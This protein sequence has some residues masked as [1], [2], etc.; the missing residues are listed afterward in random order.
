MIEKLTKIKDSIG[1]QIEYI[2]FIPS[3]G[4]FENKILSAM[5]VHRAELVVIID[6]FKKCK[7]VPSCQYVCR[8]CRSKS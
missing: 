4:P 1:K 8:S 6:D 5:K 2:E 3:R 7:C